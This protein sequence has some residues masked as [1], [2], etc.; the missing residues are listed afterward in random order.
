MI[1][2][3]SRL[4]RFAL[5]ILAL[6]TLGAGLAQAAPPSAWSAR[7]SLNPDVLAMWQLDA[8]VDPAKTA[9]GRHPDFPG[10]RALA[11]DHGSADA[12]AVTLQGR[13]DLRR[14]AHL[15]QLDALR[16]RLD[17][18]LNAAFLLDAKG[19]AVM[20]GEMPHRMPGAGLDWRYMSLSFT[21]YSAALLGEAALSEIPLGVLDLRGPAAVE[22]KG[23]LDCRSPANWT[24]AWPSPAEPA[25]VALIAI[26]RVRAFTCRLCNGSDCN[27][28]CTAESSSGEVTLAPDATLLNVGNRDVPWYQK[29][30]PAQPP[31]GNDQHP[32]LVWALYRL[33]PDG[34]VVPLGSS[35]LKHAFFAQNDLCTCQGDRILYRG[36]SDL[37][38]AETNNASAFL[39]PREEVAPRSGLWGRCGSVFDPNCDGIEDSS[40]FAT[41][42]FARRL[43]ANEADLLPALNPGATYFV[44]GW[45]VIRD[46]GN[47]DNGFAHRQ[48]LP[49]KTGSGWTFPVQGTLRSG[50]LLHRWVDPT[51]PSATQRSERVDTVD[52]RVQLA[53]RVEAISGGF[54]YRYALMNL[55]Y[56]QASFEGSGS[57]LRLLQQRGVQGLILPLGASDLLDAPVFRDDD[58]EAGN[59]WGATAGSSTL[60]LQAPTTA[61]LGWGRLLTVSFSSPFPPAP[62][63]ATLSLGDTAAAVTTLVPSDPDRLLRDGFEA[64]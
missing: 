47:L 3:M 36:C 22:P 46:D 44:E 45:Y 1:R 32:Y 7:I 25:D 56:A 34:A 33:D 35:G 63:A 29:F 50:P 57:D 5:P 61:G 42:N 26:D 19:R 21:P 27:S 49:T 14:G 2:R 6:L 31:Y 13:L 41:D 55:D 11:W 43:R 8:R 40:G 48:V 17:S 52:G 23:S 39:G 9:E 37:Y 24:L 30:F 62:A 16:L 38:S 60:S 18:G 28:L 51:A 58:R 54:R 10:Y 64:R 12:Q 4:R 20:V 15:L 53:V 59:A